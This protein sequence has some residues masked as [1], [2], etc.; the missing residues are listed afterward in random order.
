LHTDAHNAAALRVATWTANHSC[1]RF[2]RDE[3][4]GRRNVVAAVFVMMFLKG[5]SDEFIDG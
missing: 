2:Q 1:R 5:D 4:K 3:I